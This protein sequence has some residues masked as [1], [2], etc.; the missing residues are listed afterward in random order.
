[1]KGH[2]LADGRKLK[3]PHGCIALDDYLPKKNYT[4]ISSLIIKMRDLPVNLRTFGAQGS[5]LARGAASKTFSSSSSLAA[6]TL[7]AGTGEACGECTVSCAC[8]ISA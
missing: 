4:Y 5:A 8:K 1:M 6:L 3:T 2:S 7:G